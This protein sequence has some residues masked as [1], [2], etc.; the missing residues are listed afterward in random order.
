M[1]LARYAYWLHV[2]SHLTHQDR[3]VAVQVVA[4]KSS[5]HFYTQQQVDEAV[6]TAL[7]PPIGNVGQHGSMEIDAEGVFGVKVW[8]DADEWSVSGEI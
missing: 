7:E 8:T 4:T 5:S 3:N 2:G 1:L 6:R